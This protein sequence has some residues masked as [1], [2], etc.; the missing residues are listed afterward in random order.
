MFMTLRR[1][2]SRSQQIADVA[3]GYLKFQAVRK[4]TRGAAKGARKA[5]KGTAVYQVAKRTPFVKRIPV[6][7]AA[8]AG[9]SAVAVVVAKKVRGGDDTAPAAA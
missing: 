4:T 1:K 5:A 8:A 6:L 2:K 3:A 7:A 9:V